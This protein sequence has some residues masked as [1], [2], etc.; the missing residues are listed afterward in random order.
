MEAIILAGGK[1]ERLQSVVSDVPKPMAPIHARPFL[2]W[3]M[4]YWMG[5]KVDRFILAVGYKFDLIQKH[6]GPKYKNAALDYSIEREPLGTGGGLLLALSRLKEK[7]P[8]L[9]LNGDTFFEMSLKDLVNQHIQKKS[10]WSM[11]LAEASL[12]NR[13]SGIQ[14][15]GNGKVIAMEVQ[16]TRA[17]NRLVNGGVY[18]MNPDVF[19]GLDFHQPKKISLETEV[20]PRMI[21]EKKPLYGFLSKGRFID[22]GIPED[23]ER[24]NRIFK[25]KQVV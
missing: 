5:E 18:L 24:A 13:Y 25:A 20:I 9:V 11:A 3:L 7:K 16:N 19:S 1:G 15:D 23:Y 14:L 17:S 8:F 6:F 12:N 4:D 21:S 2:E 22:I 10:I